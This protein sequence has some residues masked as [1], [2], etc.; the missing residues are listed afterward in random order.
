MHDMP[1]LSPNTRWES[2]LLWSLVVD[3]TKVGGGASRIPLIDGLKLTPSPQTRK[4]R[5]SS[6][7]STTTLSNASSLSNSTSTRSTRPFSTCVLSPHS[8]FP[9]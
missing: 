7:C 2:S 3:A 9:S 6:S 4:I 5:L 8:Y 1:P